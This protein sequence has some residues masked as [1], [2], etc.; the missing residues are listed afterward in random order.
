[1]NIVILIDETGRCGT[2]LNAN[3]TVGDEYSGLATLLANLIAK[4]ADVLELEDETEEKQQP[5]TMTSTIQSRP[6]Q[7]SSATKER[8]YPGLRPDPGVVSWMRTAT[9]YRVG[10]TF[11][12][13][14][15]RSLMLRSSPS[16]TLAEE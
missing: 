12:S 2:P 11:R 3:P 14:C 15:V 9:R 4:Y 10:T 16:I 1:M 13:S 7:F 5:G 8:R 6:V